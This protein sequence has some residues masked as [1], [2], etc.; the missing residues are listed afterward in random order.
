MKKYLLSLAVICFA[1]SLSAQNKPAH[2]QD[3]TAQFKVAAQIT[4]P[5]TGNEQTVFKEEP[6]SAKP[7]TENFQKDFQEVVIGHSYYD[8]QTNGCIQKR[9]I[10]NDDS[11]EAAW[12]MAQEPTFND[13]GT[14][15]VKY[16]NTP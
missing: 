8:T 10:R 2:T 7:S 13:R 6:A 15:Y 12:T 1:V 16:E 4:K 9:L 11:I 14:G 3:D 5:A